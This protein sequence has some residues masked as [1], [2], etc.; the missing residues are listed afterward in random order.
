MAGLIKAVRSGLGFFFFFFAQVSW[1]LWSWRKHGWT[2][3]SSPIKPFLFFLL[4]FAEVLKG[5]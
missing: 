2:D 3:Q 4:F 1:A 5:L